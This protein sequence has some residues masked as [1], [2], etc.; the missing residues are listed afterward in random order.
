MKI[1]NTLTRT[2]DEIKPLEDNKIKLYTCG[3]TVY[4]QPHIGN[5]VAYIYW[6]IL[7]RTLKDEGHE[8]TRVQNITDVG[9]LTS[10]ED[11]GEDKMLKGALSEGL[12]AW[13]VAEKY[14]A[15]ADDEAYNKLGLIRPDHMP[16]A[17]EYIPQQIAFVQELER[18]GYTYA[19]E[20]GVYF[21]T[22]KLQNYGEL[23]R[24]DI[25]GL[26]FGARVADTGK[27]NPTDFAVW[28]FSDPAEK[29]DME[30]WAPF[31]SPTII[32]SDE[33]HPSG[34]SRAMD[35][36][37]VQ[38]TSE[39]RTEPYPKYAE[40]SSGDSAAAVRHEAVSVASSAGQQ[41][42][43]IHGSWGFPG[44]HLECSVMARELLGDQIDIHTGG[45]DHIP[46]H[47]TNEI[48]QT[49][50]V[51]GKQ[52][53][54]VWVHNNHLKVDGE[55]MSK[56]L[57]NIYTLQDIQDKG[58][59][60]DAFKL[61]ILSKHYKTE[62]NFTWDN[63]QSFQN[64]LDKLRSIAD[65]RWQA[66]DDENHTS[67]DFSNVSTAMQEYLRDDL[68]TTQALTVFNVD[69]IDDIEETGYITSNEHES[70]VQVIAMFE[71]LFGIKLTTN[72]DISEPQKE[73][74]QARETARKNSDWALS[75]DL[76][77]QLSSQSIFV[78]DTGQGQIWFRQ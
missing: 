20:D 71:S 22:S 16:R 49:E 59:S 78:K 39:Q 51:T 3:L 34:F 27:K 23:A 24:L 57:G 38:E 65:L 28:K 2:L 19:I 7:V 48:A 33:K 67:R 12:T 35:V 44:W 1:Q 76:R 17:T 31:A 30:W 58:F 45:I 68:N 46:V 36:D 26:Q 52:F 6:D 62:G 11:A 56:S 5:W 47:H 18:K 66:V 14:I 13:Q 32:T 54:K 70:F 9:H 41:D 74:L 8:V 29:R 69:F 61:M 72:S 63:L 77:E 15:I 60:I 73:L 25:D 43:P 42:E 55:K 64:R 40:G 10:D 53:S 4:S 75:D 37:A 21:D 50:A